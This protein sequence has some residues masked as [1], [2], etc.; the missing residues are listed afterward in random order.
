MSG[1]EFEGGCFCGAVRYAVRD[2]PWWVVN[3]H[4]NSCRRSTGAPFSTYGCW[5]ERQFDLLAGRLCRHDGGNGTVRDF[6]ADCGTTLALRG[7]RWP[8]EVHILTASL[9]DAADFAPSM[10]VWTEDALPWVALG[11]LPSSPR[12]G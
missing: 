2:R 4:C 8:G 6:C 5:P 3:C 12:S 1:A 7:R 10:H 11:G 9:D